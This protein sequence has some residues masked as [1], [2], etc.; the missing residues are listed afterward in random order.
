MTW[1]PT[2]PTGRPRLF[3]SGM[4]GR[5]DGSFPPGVAAQTRL[6]C[7]RLQAVLAAASD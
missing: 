7:E 1:L 3:L 4:V 5:K 2:G 6:V